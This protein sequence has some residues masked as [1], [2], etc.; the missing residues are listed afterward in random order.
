MN[1]IYTAET[2]YLGVYIKE[3]L[4]WSTYVQSLADELSKISF[5]IKSL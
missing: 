5:M 1:L 4:K 2:K 3:T